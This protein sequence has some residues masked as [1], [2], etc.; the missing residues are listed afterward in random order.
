[1]RIA[2]VA[3]SLGA[4]TALV[5]AAPASAATQPRHGAVVAAPADFQ[6]EF[7]FNWNS[8]LE[9]NKLYS[10]PAGTLV[11]QSDGN[12]VVYSQAGV[13]LWDSRTQFLGKSAVFQSDGN[14]VIYDGFGRGVWESATTGSGA[15]LKFQSDGNLVLYDLAGHA[16]WSTGTGHSN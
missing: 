11:F 3:V 10:T 5:T 6:Q 2:A 13:A 8:S 12:L 14:F 16:I 7:V 1:M 4:A 9:V 15:Q